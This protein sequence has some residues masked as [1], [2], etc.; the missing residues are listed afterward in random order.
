MEVKEEG[1][2]PLPEHLAAWKLAG[3]WSHLASYLGEVSRTLVLSEHLRGRQRV[4][5]PPEER[6]AEY[7]DL[8]VAGGYLW[9]IVYVKLAVSSQLFETLGQHL[10]RISCILELL[11]AWVS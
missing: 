3:V 9:G 4:A 1:Q 2:F 5:S 8:M 6:G 11:E 10:H 7:E